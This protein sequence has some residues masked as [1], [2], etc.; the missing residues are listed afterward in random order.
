MKKWIFIGCG[1]VLLLLVGALGFLGWAFYG[2]VMDM[3]NQWELERPRF[4]ALQTRFPFEPAAQQG[5]DTDRFVEHLDLRVALAEEFLAMQLN[6]ARDVDDE[7]LGIVDRMRAPFIHFTALPSMVAAE[8]EDAK[9]SPAEFAWNSRLLWASLRSLDKGL[10]GEALA[11]LRDRYSTLRQMYDEAI[12]D[13][14]EMPGLD[15]LIGPDED[16]PP[17]S[18]ELVQGLLAMDV[19]RALKAV[20]VLSAEPLAMQATDP[21]GLETLIFPGQHGQMK[22]DLR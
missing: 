15:E 14:N 22:L 10:G 5:L 9:M 11:P 2:P 1:S 21:E 3:Y 12:K 13:D 7:S 6:V 18:L 17:G 19:D 4:E 20:G 8:F 16:F